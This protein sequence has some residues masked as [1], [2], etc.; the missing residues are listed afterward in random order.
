M[1]TRAQVL[2]IMPGAARVVDNYIRPLNAALERFEINSVDRIR[3]FLAQTAHESDELRQVEENLNYSAEGLARTWP[4]R[5]AN[6]DGTPN[7]LAVKLHRNPVAIANNV[8][9]DRMGNRDEAS[10][11]G[12]RHRGA[13]AIQLTG[14]ENQ[15][16]AALYFDV[17]FDHIGDWLRTPEGAITSAAW[18]WQSHGCNELA[19]A[20]NYLRITKVINGGT[21]GQA[22][23]VAYLEAAKGAIYA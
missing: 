18:C 21:I 13:G 2:A 22:A 8:Y 20:G 9:A 3:P 17:D 23:R 11:D 12:W 7:A 4:S 1:V 16:A 15:L 6:D 5:Y 10:G 14:R 19:D